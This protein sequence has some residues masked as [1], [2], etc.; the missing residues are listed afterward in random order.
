MEKPVLGYLYQQIRKIEWKIYN[1]RNVK[2]KR[3]Q[4]KLEMIIKTDSV[5]GKKHCLIS[6]V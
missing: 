6:M 3:E 5:W 2:T 1:T 4:M